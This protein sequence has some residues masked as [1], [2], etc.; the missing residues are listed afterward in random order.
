MQRGI[1]NQDR[2]AR[3]AGQRISE[4]AKWFV[5]GIASFLILATFFSFA[6]LQETK[7]Y[8]DLYANHSSVGGLSISIAGFI[9]TIWTVSEGARAN[10]LAQAQIK[11][12]AE[13]AREETRKLLSKIRLSS[14]RDLCD[15]TQSYTDEARH[16]IRTNL[17]MRAAEK[18]GDA[19]KLVLRLLD[20]PDLIDEERTSLRAIVEDL[21]TTISFIERYRLKANSTPG[22]P[23]TSWLPWFR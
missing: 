9:L 5:Y 12:E 18:C 15:Q 19:R 17:W 6:Y 13:Q 10:K 8:V 4:M 7:F 16:A 11:I 1:L 23:K 14:I 2:F 22:L 21:Q 20:F 3:G